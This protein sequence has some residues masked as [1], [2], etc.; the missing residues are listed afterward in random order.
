MNGILGGGLPPGLAGWVMSQQMREQSAGNQLGQLGGILNI[1]HQ[2]QTQPLQLQQLQNQIQGQQRQQEALGNF[3]QQLPEG[4]RQKF[5]VAPAEYMKELNKRYVVGGAL[6]GGAGGQPLYE[7]P[8]EMKV[9]P[10]GQVYDP[11]AIKPG[12]VMADPN[13]PF[14]VGAGGVAVPNS[15]YQDYELNKAKAG[16]PVTNVNVSTEKKYGEQF[17]SAIAKDDATMREAAIK[18]PELAD[19]SNRIRQ[20]LTENPITGTAADFRLQFAKAAKLAGLSN[21]DQPENTEVL[22]AS[23]AQNT[24]DAIKASGLGSGSG[25][26]NADRDFLEKAV[27]GKITMQKESINRLA[28]LSHRAA[29]KSAERWSKRVTEIPE[30]A[31]SGTGIKREPIRVAPLYMGRRQAD[32]AQS[33]LQQADA[34]L[35]GQ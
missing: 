6:V 25:F 5:M 11:R 18:A 7:A 1:Q 9:G 21:S 26:S 3:A 8:R 19:R 12:E 4:E 34:I 15:A 14:Q 10:S 24:L 23:L 30:D 28:E 33:L 13:K 32:Q 27:G 16:K 35:G 20:V 17:A 22:A 31:L 2:M 29:S